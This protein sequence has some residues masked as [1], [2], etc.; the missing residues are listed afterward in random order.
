[1]FHVLNVCCLVR[2]LRS[3]F[4]FMFNASRVNCFVV[5]VVLCALYSCLF[6][7]FHVLKVCFIVRLL[8]FLIVFVF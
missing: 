5:L 8:R 4:V 7:V 3:L 2:V 6:C 1:M